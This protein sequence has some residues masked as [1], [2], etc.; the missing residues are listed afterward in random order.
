MKILHIEVTG[1]FTEDAKYQEN[2]LLDE[3]KKLGHDVV[4]Y[5]SCYCWKDGKKEYVGP[6]RKTMKNGVT[7]ERLEY[8]NIFNSFISQKIRRIAD[9]QTK[10]E[11]EKPDLIM[12]HNG[13]TAIVPDV[14]KYVK[15]HRNVTFVSDSH[16]DPLNSATNLL[17][18][19]LHRVVYKRY[20]K[21]LFRHVKA[22]YCISPEV[23]EY[24]SKLYGL[25]GEKLK[26]LPLGGVIVGDKDYKAFRES[27]RRELSLPESVIH[28]VHSG[29]LYSE[30]R[31][32]N[33]L[34]AFQRVKSDKLH[35]TIIGSAEGNVLKC[36]ED[37]SAR[38]SR[39]SWLGWKSGDELTEYLCSGDVYVLPGDVSATVQTS[40]CCRCVPVVYPFELYRT[41]NLD[42]LCYV[43]D[44][45]ELQ[46]T[47]QIFLEDEN[48]LSTIRCK[49][50]AYAQLYLDYAS[51]AER[52]I[53]T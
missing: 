37:G 7:L 26:L 42:E 30:K 44:V 38:D 14:C 53:L 22:L 36:I 10:L 19:I 15:K 31:T 8:V 17:S 28:I 11:S 43:R 3:H 24:I 23:K 49:S 35:L 16:T 12:L 27:R 5:A 34:E 32:E 13:Q 20:M 46:H 9:I 18:Y 25:K 47:L 33:L 4:M 51:Q 45:D 21:I 40:M 41:M 48:I 6:V 29:K 2:M 52:L 1:P 39:I 50:Y